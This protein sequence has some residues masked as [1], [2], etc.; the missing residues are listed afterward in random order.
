MGRAAAYDIKVLLPTL[1]ILSV[2]LAAACAFG[3]QKQEPG[4]AK[5]PKIG[6]G[7]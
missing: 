4:S 5:G 2:A 1:G 7:G 6:L 3:N